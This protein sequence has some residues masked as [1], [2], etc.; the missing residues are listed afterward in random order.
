M[1]KIIALFLILTMLLSLTACGQEGKKSS[2]KDSSAKT[3]SVA[4]GTDELAAQCLDK[5]LNAKTVDE[6]TKHITKDSQER[7]ESILEFYEGKSFS[8]M[9]KYE[10]CFKGYDI[11]YYEARDPESNDLLE[12]DYCIMSF[13]GDKYLLC[14][15][16]DVINELREKFLCS[17]CGGSGSLT[18]GTDAACAT[19][20]GTGVQYIP[21]AYYDVTLQMWMGQNISCSGCGGSGRLTGTS[22]TT[23]C[24]GCNGK[25]IKFN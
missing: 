14:L 6:I 7:A 4:K 17:L 5:V 23:V 13:D 16:A 3:S 12:K 9:A 10:S 15:N 25:G 19:C 1:K 18:T 22:S 11:F 20:G 2:N 24:G 21:S 8:L